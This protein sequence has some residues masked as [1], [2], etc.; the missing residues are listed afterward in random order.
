VKHFAEVRVKDPGAVEVAADD[1]KNPVL[2]A[3][4]GDGSALLPGDAASP[5]VMARRQQHQISVVW[6]VARHWLTRIPPG[7][8]RQRVLTGFD[9]GQGR[10]KDRGADGRTLEGGRLQQLRYATDL[11]A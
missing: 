1:R 4:G 2:A 6:S 8:P 10:S 11:H 9:L 5:K 7:S 3:D